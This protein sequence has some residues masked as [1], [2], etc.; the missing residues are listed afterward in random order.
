MYM[1]IINVYVIK[2]ITIYKCIKDITRLIH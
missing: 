2:Q 1:F